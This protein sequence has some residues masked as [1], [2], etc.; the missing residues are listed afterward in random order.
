MHF[1]RIAESYGRKISISCEFRFTSEYPESVFTRI[2]KGIQ[3]HS[4][5]LGIAFF[6]DSKTPEPFRE[7]FPTPK[8]TKAL[9]IPKDRP[10]SGLR[11]LAPAV[12]FSDGLASRFKNR[13]TVSKLPSFVR[14]RGIP[15]HQWPKFGPTC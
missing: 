13:K 12:N 5:P 9:S 8:K 15:A 1:A 3:A 14:A 7:S 4:A 6:Q 2:D 11:Y 10:H